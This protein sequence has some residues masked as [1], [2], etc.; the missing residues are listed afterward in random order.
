[1]NRP[2]TPADRPDFLSLLADRLRDGGGPSF[3]VFSPADG[4]RVAA[5]PDATP[6]DARRAADAAVQAYARWSRTGAHQRARLLQAWF[7]EIMAHREEIARVISA[8]MGK[9]VSEAR[10]EV[11][12]A[13]AYI[14]LYAEEAKR[15]RG[16]AFSGPDARK[17][18]YATPRPVGPVYAITPWNFPAA[19]ITR[20]AAPALAAGCTAIVKPAPQSPLTALFLSWLWERAGGPAGTLQTLPT[21]DA[22]GVSQVM[23][24]DPRIRKLTFTGST[25]V[26]RSLYRQ[27]AGTLKRVSLEL[28][29]HAPFLVFDD[30]DLDDA[31]EQVML[32]KF[33][34][35]G[36]TC[37]CTNRIYVQRAILPAFVA[38]LARRVEAL[39]MGDPADERTEV[40]PLVD[41]RGLDKVAGQVRDAL[42]K[43]AT[44]VTGGRAA[45]GLFFRPTVLAG[46]APGMRILEEET[47]GPVAPILAFDT[48]EEA[49][50]QAN[51]TPFGLAAYLYTRDLARAHRVSEALEYGI[52]GVNDG[53]PSTAWAPF[54]GVKDSGL[55]REGGHWG[56]E[57]YLDLKYVSV[58]LPA[59]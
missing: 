49:V 12:Y 9:P 48:E 34:N 52:V 51:D 4:R 23:F 18:L 33:R 36:Q 55:G 20:K 14:E 43:G 21:L 53:A 47:F 32:S 30:A 1:M 24:D 45:E 38:A 56:L 11:D 58:G 13:A 31:V 15:I 27:A 25:E 2:D 44:L 5:V 7:G 50:A 42:D 17:R 16:E 46:V 37:V 3:E 57:E 54:G 8:E 28:G 35:A 39:R 22:A 40:G 26:G 6:A 19:M 29:G 41:A 59:A 10:G